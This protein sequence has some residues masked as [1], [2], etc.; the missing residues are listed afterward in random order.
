[1]G[2][3]MRIALIILASAVALPALPSQAIAQQLP[4]LGEVFLAVERAAAEAD[5]AAAQPG[6]N[7]ALAGFLAT[8]RTAGLASVNLS[9]GCADR[10]V[11]TPATFSRQRQSLW[12]FGLDGVSTEARNAVV[13]IWQVTNVAI[14]GRLGRER[15]EV[16]LEPFFE[17][18]RCLR[19]GAMNQSLERLRRYEIKFGPGSP[20]LNGLEVA[21]NYIAQRAPLFGPNSD[22]F[23]GPFELVSSYAP[24][25]IFYT[26]K[27]RAASVAEFGLRMYNFSAAGDSTSWRRRLLRPRY[28]AAGVAVLNEREE[29]LAWPWEGDARTGPFINWGPLRVAYI[30][31]GRNRLL[32]SRNVQLI[33]LVF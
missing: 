9:R 2:C 11:I 30:V 23:P 24:T 33:P 6:A 18:S 28:W 8:A 27:P 25:Y 14:I 20:Q 31:E 19:E 5:L 21:T 7:T 17:V 22:G 29:T 13:G 16:L 1:M 10:S 12:D 4:P 3:V 26:D 32:V 15:S